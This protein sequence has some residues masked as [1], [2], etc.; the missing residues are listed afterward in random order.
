MTDS[1]DDTGNDHRP[2]DEERALPDGIPDPD[3]PP[4]FESD[5]HVLSEDDLVYPTFEFEEGAISQDDGFALQR[6]LDREEM[7]SWL[8]SL[9][10]ALVSHDLAVEGENLRATF[11]FAPDDVE[12]SFDPDETH[13]GKLTV[14]LSLDAK[15]MCYERADERPRGNRGNRGFIPLEMLTSDRDPETFRC[16]N[17]ISDPTIAT[18]DRA[19]DE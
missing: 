12:M 8:D 15:V 14:T 9:S 7:G 4:D 10:G 16:Y 18:D 6:E 13:R 17:W 11:G 5:S 2:A 1:N 19:D 3:D